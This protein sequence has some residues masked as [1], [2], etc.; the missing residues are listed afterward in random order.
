MLNGTFS[1][2]YFAAV[3][4]ISNAALFHAPNLTDELSTPAERR[5]NQ[6]DLERRRTLNS[7][8]SA[9]LCDAGAAA[10]SYGALVMCRT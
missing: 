1:T 3:R 9:A 2:L 4:L 5:L 10:D 8:G 6:F 7:A